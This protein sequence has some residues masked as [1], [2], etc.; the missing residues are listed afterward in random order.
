VDE[1]HTVALGKDELRVG[2]A[3]QAV[4]STRHPSAGRRVANH[5]PRTQQ[6]AG[7]RASG[8]QTSQPYSRHNNNII[9]RNIH[10]GLVVI[11]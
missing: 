4:V 6:S 10:A 2:A 9:Q 3:K 7:V 8:T 5:R 1:D 11:R